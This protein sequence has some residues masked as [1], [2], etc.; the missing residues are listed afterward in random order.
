LRPEKKS[1][2]ELL[3]VVDEPLTTLP[4][5]KTRPSREALKQIMDELM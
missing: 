1:F 3:N 4:Q 5:E 2:I